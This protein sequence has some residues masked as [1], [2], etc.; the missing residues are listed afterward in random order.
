MSNPSE[1]PLFDDNPF[2]DE[3]ASPSE[4]EMLHDDD[5]LP[6]D[7]SLPDELDFIVDSP[8]TLQEAFEPTLVRASAG[9]GKTYQLTAR[10]LKILMTGAPPETILAT[11]FTRKAAGEILERVLITLGKAAI[12]PSEKAI[13]ELRQQ[14]GIEGL[15]RHVCGQLFHRLL[16]NIHRLRICTLDSLFSQLARALPFELDLPPGWRLTD[17]VEEIWLRQVAIGN[18]IES[19]QP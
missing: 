10:L 11:T 19:L 7:E 9:T 2:F 4:A 17:E 16:K 13:A 12:D 18:L 5:R 14:V 3:D 6:E 8:T 15:P 1:H